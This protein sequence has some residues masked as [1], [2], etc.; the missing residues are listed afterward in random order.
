MTTETKMMASIH[1][2]LTHA[3]ALKLMKLPSGMFLS[4]ETRYTGVG[5]QGDDEWRCIA[6]IADAPMA[7][8]RPDFDFSGAHGGVCTAWFQCHEVAGTEKDAERKALA[9]AMSEMRRL[10]DEN[11]NVA[12]AIESAATR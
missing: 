11:S 8:G 12:R 1:R 5:F 2:S 4:V 7:I 6:R 10:S 9:R 3:G